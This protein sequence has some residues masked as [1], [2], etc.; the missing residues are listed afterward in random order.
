MNPGREL[1][2]VRYLQAMG[3]VVHVSRCAL[4]GAAPTRRLVLKRVER[5]PA[6]GP[7][8]DPRSALRASLAPMPS[9][10]EVP[11]HSAADAESATATDHAAPG[12]EERFSMAAVISG[13]RLWIEDLGTEALSMEQV[14]LMVAV[15]RA[16]S[17]PQCDR[18]A[19]KVAQFDWPL[20]DNP[21][22]DLGPGEARA[23]LHSFLLRQL[24]EQG[25][26]ALMCV[27]PQAAARIAGVDFPVPVQRLPASRALLEDPAGKRRLW[28]QLRG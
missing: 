8:T 22:L 11:P 10:T 5:A 20:H 2:R 24:Q 1:K 21:Q 23:A 7:A 6:P 13:G 27:G 15:G 26:E 9:A 14:Q 16:L 18:S 25:C 17:H 19:P 4:P 3:L 12:L 28:S